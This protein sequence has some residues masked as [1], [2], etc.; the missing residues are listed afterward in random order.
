MNPADW[1]GRGGIKYL[2][3]KKNPARQTKEKVAHTAEGGK[4]CD[5]V[6][7]RIL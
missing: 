5:R 7:G 2:S 3:L 6:L 4:L 1:T